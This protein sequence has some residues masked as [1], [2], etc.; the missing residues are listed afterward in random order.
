MME[1][2]IKYMTAGVCE[3]VLTSKRAAIYE[4]YALAHGCLNGISDI[5][6]KSLKYLSGASNKNSIMIQTKRNRDIFE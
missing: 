3:I 5:A 2:Y 1:D 6:T 4:A